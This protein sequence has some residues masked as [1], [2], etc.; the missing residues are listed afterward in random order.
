MVNHVAF[1]QCGIIN[2][3][4]QSNRSCA[5]YVTWI[6]RAYWHINRYFRT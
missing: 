4:S 1:G 6:H 2:F 5:K 3:T